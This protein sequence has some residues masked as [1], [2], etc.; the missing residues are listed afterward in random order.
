MAEGERWEQSRNGKK[1]N[2]PRSCEAER[3]QKSRPLALKFVRV[4]VPEGGV[5]CLT[6]SLQPDL[7]RG[8]WRES[9]DSTRQRATQVLPKTPCGSDA[10]TRSCFTHQTGRDSNL[11]PC[12]YSFTTTTYRND[13]AAKVASAQATIAL[14][15]CVAPD[16]SSLCLPESHTQQQQQRRLC[17]PPLQPFR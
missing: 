14:S 1:S 10:D 3:G 16:Q 5:W 13:H 9:N 7:V 17:W 12:S 2:P 4:C 6:D 11:G 8:C 15:G